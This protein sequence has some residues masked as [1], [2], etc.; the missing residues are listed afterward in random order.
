MERLH[1]RIISYVNQLKIRDDLPAEVALEIINIINIMEDHLQDVTLLLTPD[2][3]DGGHQFD[4]SDPLLNR[5]HATLTMSHLGLVDLSQRQY[6]QFYLITF[7]ETI[8]R[9]IEAALNVE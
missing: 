7:L 8:A 5:F 9:A 4:P 6:T 3:N 1:G 2:P